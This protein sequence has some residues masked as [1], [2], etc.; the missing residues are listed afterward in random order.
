[1]KLGGFKQLPVVKDG[2]LVGIVTDRDFRRP[3]LADDFESWEHLYRISDFYTVEEIM[4]SEV[5]TIQE[6]ASLRDAAII[7]NEKEFNSLPVISSR[8]GK[9]VG[10]VTVRDVLKAILNRL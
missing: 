9:L 8:S 1:M 5:V 3:Q 2:N 6:D 10:I 7:F 4:K